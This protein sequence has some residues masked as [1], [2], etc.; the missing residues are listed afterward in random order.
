MGLFDLAHWA[1]IRRP[2]KP[3]PGSAGHCEGD[4]MPEALSF[5]EI[6][7]QHLELLPAR[8]VLSMFTTASGGAATGSDT[9][10]TSTTTTTTTSDPNSGTGG[11]NDLLKGN[12]VLGFVGSFFGKIV[13]TK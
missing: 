9:G 6:N 8:T 3:L 10:T 2:L 11:V 12:P 5:T 4:H 1:T 13:P 7:R